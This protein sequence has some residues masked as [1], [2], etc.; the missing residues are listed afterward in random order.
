MMAPFDRLQSILSY[1]GCENFQFRGDGTGKI[2]TTGF[3]LGFVGGKLCVKNLSLNQYFYGSQDKLTFRAKYTLLGFH[4]ALA[5]MSMLILFGEAM[6]T[7]SVSRVETLMH[8]SIYMT[9]LCTFHFLEFF[10]T[11]IS[12]PMLL[13]YECKWNFITRSRIMII[14]RRRCPKHMH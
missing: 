6:T 7:A 12:Q 2:G 10:L 8:W 14:F 1:D 13:S 4:V 11:A 9:C 3:L 5:L